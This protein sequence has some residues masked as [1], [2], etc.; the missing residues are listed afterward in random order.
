M[1]YYLPSV[2]DQYYH[3]NIL[4][5]NAA[6]ATFSAI[7]R[8]LS[9]QKQPLLIVI[10]YFINYSISWLINSTKIIIPLFYEGIVNPIIGKTALDYIIE[11][12]TESLTIKTNEKM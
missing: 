8:R 2:V 11:K 9:L 10:Q 6:E 5:S 7:K 1:K 12:Q 3:R 4:T